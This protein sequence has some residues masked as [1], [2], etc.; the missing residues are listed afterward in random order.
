MIETPKDVTD[1]VDR[2]L[3]QMIRAHRL[4]IGLSQRDLAQA[5]DLTFQQIQKYE[6]GVNRISASKL[7]AA[8]RK[9]QT[10]VSALFGGLDIGG[11]DQSLLL[12]F[13]GFLELDGAA[14]L[15]RAYVTLSPHQRRRLVGLVEAMIPGPQEP[16]E[17]GPAP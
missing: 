17:R 5:L 15:A 11:Q 3:G 8:A 2:H 6:K 4:S 9:L 1:A 12:E 7:L 16:V 10:P 13:A 14:D